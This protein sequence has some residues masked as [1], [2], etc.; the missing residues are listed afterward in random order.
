MAKNDRG[1]CPLSPYVR[2]KSGH[3]GGAECQV[4]Y[5]HGSVTIGTTRKR[6]KTLFMGAMLQDGFRALSPKIE[7]T[8]LS[9][10]VGLYMVLSALFN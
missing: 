3:N 6:N 1:Q 9:F 7:G 2:V 10:V 8:L 4:R 5:F